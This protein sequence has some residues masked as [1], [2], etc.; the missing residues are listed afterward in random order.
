MKRQEYRAEET[1]KESICRINKLEVAG[2]R[3]TVA[4]RVITDKAPAW[5]SQK[6]NKDEGNEVNMMGGDWTSWRQSLEKSEP[7]MLCSGSSGILALV[8]E[9]ELL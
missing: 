7:F 3:I 5:D 2:N 1:Y 9:N 8:A 4:E 6:E